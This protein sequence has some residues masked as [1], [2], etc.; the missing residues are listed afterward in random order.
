MPNTEHLLFDVRLIRRN[1]RDQKITEEQL[2][3]ELDKL[4]D[5]SGR[6]D[7]VEIP[8][9]PEPSEDDDEDLDS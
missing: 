2:K 9:D 5:L 8:E 3:A 7:V 4:E 1:L 6:F